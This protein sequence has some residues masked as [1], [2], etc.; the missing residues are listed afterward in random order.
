MKIILIVATTCQILTLKCTK[1]DFGA[2]RTYSAPWPLA[3]VEGDWLHLPL[4]QLQSTQ[5]REAAKY[6]HIL[7]G[8]TVPQKMHICSF[9]GGVR[10]TGTICFYSDAQPLAGLQGPYKGIEGPPS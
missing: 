5:C 6:V 10:A 9:I 4:L 1:L 3:S 2:G 8:Y 7:L